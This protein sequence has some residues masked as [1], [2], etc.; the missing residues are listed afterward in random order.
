MLVEDRSAEVK[1]PDSFLRLPQPG[2]F[3]LGIAGTVVVLGDAKLQ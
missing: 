2:G 1:Q 3:G